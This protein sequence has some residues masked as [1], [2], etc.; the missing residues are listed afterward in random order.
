[1]LPRP[2]QTLLLMLASFTTSS[3]QR[4]GLRVMTFN[5]WN[6]GKNVINGREKIAKHIAL[7]DPDVVTLQETY[8]NVS[9]ELIGMLGEQWQ[10]VECPLG[11]YPDRVILT[12]HFIVPN[13]TIFT[14]A[15]VGVKILHRS[16]FMFY[17]WSVH[18]AYTSYGPYAAYN[19]LVTSID[20]I[21]AGEN[22][23]RGP[24]MKEILE[25]PIMQSWIRKSRTYPLFVC[26]DFNGPSH[27]DWVEGNRRNHGGWIVSWPATRELAQAGFIDAYRALYPDP[28][29]YPGITWSTVNKFN[30]E[31]NYT[32]QEPEDRIDFIHYLGPIRPLAVSTY[33]GSEPLQR[34]PYH[35]QNDYPSDHF[36]LFGDFQLLL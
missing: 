24:Q 30:P 8:V 5:I 28:L 25:H 18:L 16:G 27:L 35:Q 21:M 10:A 22:L 12:K 6:S 13:T 9:T 20:Q 15:G 17:I 33:S 2:L 23:G 11:N 1:M 19:K 32:I 3:G 7:V 29:Q 34:M 36:A 31:W 14:S 4:G 26:G